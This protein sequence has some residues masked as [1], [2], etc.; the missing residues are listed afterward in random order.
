MRKPG[1]VYWRANGWF[2]GG[3]GD[4]NH[5]VNSLRRRPGLASV[6]LGMPDAGNI[7]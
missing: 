4:L 6:K 3:A 7:W 1:K 5:A 2:A